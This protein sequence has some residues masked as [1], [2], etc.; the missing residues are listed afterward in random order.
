MFRLVL[1]CV[2]AWA[3]CCLLQ[4]LKSGRV[5]AVDVGNEREPK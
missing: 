5:Y 3:G 1:T 2:F 4:S